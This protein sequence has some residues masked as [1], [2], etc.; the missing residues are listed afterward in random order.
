MKQTLYI[1]TLLILST[2]AFAASWGDVDFRIMTSDDP[3]IFPIVLEFTNTQ[4]TDLNAELLIETIS[5]EGDFGD[6]EYEEDFVI[7]ATPTLKHVTLDV[8]EGEESHNVWVSV[9]VD[10]EMSQVIYNSLIRATPEIVTDS[11]PPKP[12]DVIR[13]EIDQALNEFEEEYGENP[14]ITV[15]ELVEKELEK[16][17]ELKKQVDELEKA[18]KE[19][20][21]I[22]K[23]DDKTMGN[24]IGI[25]IAIILFIIVGVIGMTFFGKRK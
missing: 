1:L 25:V 18:Q 15:Q 7:P 23:K 24:A 10:G 12:G 19:E 11:L 4:G 5:P 14:D 16:N 2:T 13:D 22:E 9:W 3:N 8:P 20:L 6:A 17:P 21:T